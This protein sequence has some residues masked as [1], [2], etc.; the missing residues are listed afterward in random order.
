MTKKRLRI[1]FFCLVTVLLII[2]LSCYQLVSINAKGK[3]FNDVQN[4]P[5]NEIGLLLGTSPITSKGE[6]NYY[7]DER[8]EATAILYHSGKVKRIVANGGDYSRNGGCNE[9]I[10][11]RDSLIKWGVPDNSISLDY[12]GTRTLH[13]IVK[14]K[15]MGSIT[16]ISQKYHNERAIYLAEHYGLQAVAYNA[17]MPNITKKKIRNISRE[18]LARVKLFIDLVG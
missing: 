6:H 4:I 12:Q 10:A 3:T 16:I 2:I 17:A 14:L 1:I 5:Y 7:F 9:L 15:D 18:F 13:S 8:I 11:M